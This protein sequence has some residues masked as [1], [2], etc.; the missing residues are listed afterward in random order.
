MNGIYQ[1]PARL[2]DLREVIGKFLFFDNEKAVAI[3]LDQSKVV[4]ALHKQADPWPRRADHLGQFFVGNPQ[5]DA[6]AARI[7]FTHC[8]SQL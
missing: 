2:G 7:L 8:A 6:D 3:G 4:E 5:F 1:H